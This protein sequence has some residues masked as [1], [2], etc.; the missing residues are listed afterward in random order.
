ML[1]RAHATGRRLRLLQSTFSCLLC[2]NEDIIASLVEGPP[3][4]FRKKSA[5]AKTCYPLVSAARNA[6]QNH[7]GLHPAGEKSAVVNYVLSCG[8]GD[9]IGLRFSSLA[10]LHV[11]TPPKKTDVDENEKR[12][13]QVY[14]IP[15]VRIIWPVVVGTQ[16]AKKKN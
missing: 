2:Y 7:A 5:L 9:P 1:S 14:T 13:T 16:I 10:E 15:D 11:L 4:D 8:G 12:A 6:F 3:V